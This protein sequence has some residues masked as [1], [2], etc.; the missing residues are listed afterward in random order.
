[1]IVE[2]LWKI[3]QPC[4]RHPLA[5][6]MYRRVVNFPGL[7]T[8]WKPYS[9][10]IQTSFPYPVGWENSLILQALRVLHTTTYRHSFQAIINYRAGDITNFNSSTVLNFR[11]TCVKSINKFKSVEWENHRY[12]RSGKWLRIKNTIHSQTRIHLLG[13]LMSVENQKELCCFWRWWTMPLGT[14]RKASS[15]DSGLQPTRAGDSSF[16]ID[17]L[18]HN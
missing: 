4:H 5:R 3:L 11:G 6:G 16:L 10:T 9:M 8:P 12:W 2:W 13:C 18:L 7:D 1:M 14:L 15:P 17:A